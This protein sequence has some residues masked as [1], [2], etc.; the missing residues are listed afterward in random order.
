MPDITMCAPPC[1]HLAA[2]CRRSVESGTKP[3]ERQSW[4]A[5][6]LAWRTGGAVA[7][8]NYWPINRTTAMGKT[9]N[10]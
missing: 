6:A 7:C 4:S 5:F 3:S 10:G 1:C 2:T 8:V 9:P